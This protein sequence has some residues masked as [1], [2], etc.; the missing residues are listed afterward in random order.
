M[1]FPL[2][3]ASLC[4]VAAGTQPV[5]VDVTLPPGMVNFSSSGRVSAS[6]AASPGAGAEKAIDGDLDAGSWTSAAGPSPHWI[7]IDFDTP[8]RTE[9]LSLYPLL[10]PGQ[11][12]WKS[13]RVE[14]KE[15]GGWRE[16]PQAG[17]WIMPASMHFPVKARIQGARLVVSDA[18]GKGRVRIAEIEVVGP[19][20]AAEQPPRPATTGF[21]SLEGF[22]LSRGQSVD[23]SRLDWRF[24]RGDDPAWSQAGYDDSDWKKIEVGR[25]WL[26]QD[27]AQPIGWYRASFTLPSEW[28]GGPV[29]L[30]LG[31]LG[32]RGLVHVNGTLVGRFGPSPSTN[33]FSKIEV[34]RAVKFLP[35]ETLR[36]GGVNTLSIRCE[37]GEF[38]GLY[39]GPYRAVRLS[40]KL[41][42]IVLID[43]EWKVR[44]VDAPLH[45]LST[46]EH[47]NNYRLGEPVKLKPLATPLFDEPSRL[48]LS[49]QVHDARGRLVTSGSFERERR[50]GRIYHFHSVRL[51]VERPGKYV[52]RVVCRD[53][54]RELSSAVLPFQIHDRLAAG[55]FPLD[56]A[57][58]MVSVPDSPRSLDRESIGHYGGNRFRKDGDKHILDYDLSHGNAN[59]NL[60]NSTL[61]TSFL[62]GPLIFSNNYKDPPR[63]LLAA[64]DYMTE[65]SSFR[66]LEGRDGLWSFGFVGP[67]HG[68]MPEAVQVETSSWTGIQYSMDYPIEGRR[69]RMRFHENSL[70]PAVLADLEHS[71]AVVFSGM[72]QFGLGHPSQ[73]TFADHGRV[74]NV[75]LREG[76]RIDL[77][78]RSENWIL[79]HFSGAP[80]FDE[81]D[82]PYLVVT[83]KK[84]RS[85]AVSTAGIEFDFGGQPAGRIWLMPLYGQRLVTLL[86]TQGWRDS[87]PNAVL[88]DVRF[89]SGALLAYPVT[90]R[91]HYRVLGERNRV[92]IDEVFEYLET[93][94]QWGTQ[95]IHIALAPPVVALAAR[96]GFPV[97]FA[98]KLELATAVGASRALG[99]RSRE[100][101]PVCRR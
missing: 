51:P 7:Q 72:G 21:I 80:G 92:V 88:Q 11:P 4:I 69:S 48:E 71:R 50:Q 97:L 14:I 26:E 70:S 93:A 83:Q 89:W 82:V 100:S 55:V 3:L 52:A 79:F 62:P 60:V 66:E 85:L 36:Y 67:E 46:H 87:L 65:I 78:G 1:R 42:P 95:P 29:A 101:S 56:R 63:R 90:C 74:R 18:G 23:L 20:E 94:D 41:V 5:R 38:G 35:P 61:V 9:V 24:R 19:R 58:E 8:R 39:K 31:Y 40:A 22:D 13:Y 45:F 96:Y 98:Q 75:G 57:L 49:Y 30:D 68:L 28:K 37:L 25:S 10:D 17:A 59:G 84:A 32:W 81:F 6:S 16:L 77:Q 64:S 44:G 91:E 54:G 86:E 47:L 43:A 2:F 76:A 33:P 99:V 73:A 12:H 53:A 27:P 34:V 15:E